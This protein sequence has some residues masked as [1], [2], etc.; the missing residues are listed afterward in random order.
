MEKEEFKKFLNET[1]ETK[2]EDPNLKERVEAEKKYYIDMVNKLYAQI[3][4]WF[5]DD[6]PSIQLSTERI[7][8]TEE[9]TGPYTI[10]EL[11]LTINSIP[12]KITPIGT[13][14]IAS[15][16]RVDLKGPN[17][18]IKIVICDEKVT[19]PRQLIKCYDSIEEREKD[20][21]KAKE[22]MKHT[23]FIWKIVDSDPPVSFIELSYNTFTDSIGKVIN[24]N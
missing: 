16:G 8:I 19:H 18:E 12:L 3:K 1:T 20:E 10:D 15:R 9:L 17:G 13:Y 4:E 21:A 5:K 23:N 22:E 11:T 6:E 14:V 24:G 7:T 2:Q